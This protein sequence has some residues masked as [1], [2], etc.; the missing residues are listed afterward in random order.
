M[1]PNW[2]VS[3]VCEPLVPSGG[4]QLSLGN[5]PEVAELVSQTN[6]KVHDTVV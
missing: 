2:G 3:L 5:G 6:S 1:G 4:R